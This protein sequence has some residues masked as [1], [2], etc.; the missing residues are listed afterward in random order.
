VAIRPNVAAAVV[1]QITGDESAAEERRGA[2][3]GPMAASRRRWPANFSRG[4]R[5]PFVTY[6]RRLLLDV[7][8]ASVRDT[9]HVAVM[10]NNDVTDIATSDTGFDVVTGV[11]RIALA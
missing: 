10:L 11:R 2:G 5:R 3:W 4:P 1:T 8:G 6:T 7:R 9:V